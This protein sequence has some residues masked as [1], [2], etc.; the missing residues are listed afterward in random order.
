MTF[1]KRTNV[2]KMVVG[3]TA[4]GCLRGSCTTA[5]N[6]LRF[7][8]RHCSYQSSDFIWTIIIVSYDIIHRHL[9]GIKKN[10]DSLWF[11]IRKVPAICSAH[12]VATKLNFRHP[13]PPLDRKFADIE[14]HSFKRMLWDSWKQSVFQRTFEFRN[15]AVLCPFRRPYTTS[16]AHTAPQRE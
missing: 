2:A 3:N 5:W 15:E 16:G 9:F 11:S 8:A 6:S 10:N 14:L 4:D 1:E 7:K 13:V 12:I